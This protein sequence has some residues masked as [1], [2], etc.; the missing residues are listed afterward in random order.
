MEEPVAAFRKRTINEENRGDILNLI[1]RKKQRERENAKTETPDGFE[2]TRRKGMSGRQ[3]CGKT[4]KRVKR[5]EIAS[6]SVAD[7]A[8][9]KGKASNPKGTPFLSLLSQ[10]K[11]HRKTCDRG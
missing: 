6:G 4:G 9:P 5:G 11:I 3:P 7:Q 2:V 1:S 8:D 10:A